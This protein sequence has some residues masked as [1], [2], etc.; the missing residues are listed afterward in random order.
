MSA[1][2]EIWGVLNTTPDSFSDGG[3]YL[4]A[5]S[6]RDRV[7]ELLALGADVIDIGG[8]STR[9]P[10][11]NYGR[12]FEPIAPEE[13]IRRVRPALDVAAELGARTSIDTT[14]PEVAE[15]ALDLGARVVN[16]V[17]LE[18]PLPLLTLVASRGADLVLM[19]NRGRGE[20]VDPELEGDALFD[21]V[22]GGLMRG[23]E[24]ARAAGV[25]GTIYLDIGIGF[26]KTT[27]QS[28]E[29]LENLPALA[30]SGHPVY[31]GASRKSLIAD[32]EEREGAPRSTPDR[33]LG[34]SLAIAMRAAELGAH[35]LRVHDVAE[36]RQAVLIARALRRAR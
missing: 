32:L 5:D 29:C 21:E 19:H 1:L 17:G 11:R 20:A 31:V 36:T 26:A 25:S 16:Y 6:A 12:G 30:R 4:E 2:P 10:G 7:R 13:E 3:R 15:V 34:G 27:A 22:F 18:P 9:P 8:E 33:R 35:A 14:K 23:A 24:R 28:L